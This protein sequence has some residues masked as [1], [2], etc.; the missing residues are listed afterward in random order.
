MMDF[1][2][3]FA[4]LLQDQGIRFIVSASSNFPIL[5]GNAAF[6]A[7]STYLPD[8]YSG[9]GLKVLYCVG[10]DTVLLEE[11]VSKAA[12]GNQSACGVYLTCRQLLVQINCLPLQHSIH[13]ACVLCVANTIPSPTEAEMEKAGAIL[14]S[15]A[16]F[17]IMAVGEEWK[18][19]FGFSCEELLGRSLKLVQGP[20]T[21]TERFKEMMDAVRSCIFHQTTLTV[22]RKDGSHCSVRLRLRPIEHPGT[23]GAVAVQAEAELA[24]AP[25]HVE[26]LHRLD[27]CLEMLL[28]N[29][30]LGSAC[31]APDGPAATGSPPPAAGYAHDC[32]CEPTGFSELAV[33][34]P[35]WALDHVCGLL[36]ELHCAGLVLA[37]EW[38]GGGAAAGPDAP[39]P[40]RVLADLG[41]VRARAAAA[42]QCPTGLL[43]FW[44]LAMAEGAGA[45]AAAA[46]AEASPWERCGGGA[47]V[48]TDFGFLVASDR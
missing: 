2:A 6:S 27:S 32:G 5:M 23:P 41:A 38:A 29:L 14:S 22:Y 16:P 42:A 4:A 18:A 9:C 31:D 13:G 40:L 17:H 25:P 10:T 45:A 33:R 26:P 37:W 47:D 3:E 7:M 43:C 1:D 21:D 39:P 44:L 30:D 46:A 34:P 12:A 35:E 15:K 8:Q 20:S 24:D 36:S 48:A 19:L 28:S 11:T